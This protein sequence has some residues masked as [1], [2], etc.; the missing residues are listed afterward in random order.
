M[1]SS[2]IAGEWDLTVPVDEAELMAELRR[3]G[4][5]PGHR[6]Q[7]RIVGEQPTAP[8]IQDFCGSLVGFPEPTWT[9]FEHAGEEARG[10]FSVT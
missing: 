10:D 2:E 7:V 8:A 3:H 9:D 5:R 4:V 6:V 1:S